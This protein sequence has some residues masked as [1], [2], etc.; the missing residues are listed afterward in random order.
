MSNLHR[1]LNYSKNYWKELTISILAAIFCG[2]FSAAPSWVVQHT[3]DDIFVKGL[4]HLIIPFIIGFILLFVCKGITTYFSSYYMNWVGHRVINDIRK[5]LFDRIIY[6]PL[7]FFKK[8]TTGELLAHFLNDIRMIQNAS[9]SAIKHGIRSAFEAVALLS[10]AI[11][12]NPKLSILI[13]ILAP[14]IIISIRRMG[15]AVRATAIT[16]QNEIGS[17]SSLLQETFVGVREIKA[18]NAEPY[19]CKRFKDH[20][21]RCFISLMNNVHA[22]SVGPAFIETI[23]MAG[24]SIIFYIAAHQV[25]QGTITPG[26]LTSFFAAI[27]LAF[28][29]IKRLLS[30]YTDIQNGLAAAD[31]IFAIMDIPCTTQ[32][33]TKQLVTFSNQVRFENVTFHYSDESPILQNSSFSIFKGEKIGIIGPSGAGKSTACDLILGFAKP[34]SGTVY[35]D[36]QDISTVT[37]QS[38]REQI[39]YVSQ[40]P[41]LF[42]DSIF[43]NITYATPQATFQE[44]EEAARLANIYE[45]IK[46]LPYQWD[47]LVGENGSLLSGGQKQRLTI[48]RALL[49]KPAILILDE[50][51]SALDT[52]SEELISRAIENLSKTITV[53]AVSHRP[54][55]MAKMDRI[56][57]IHDKKFLEIT[58]ETSLKVMNASLMHPFEVQAQ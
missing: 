21:D 27:L 19:E 8:R 54:S 34:I 41:F 30:A 4:T 10:V 29:P 24:A 11:I 55:L 38:L 28:Q 18:F 43:A 12:Q 26:Q 9:S 51:T 47:T 13:A 3:V 17:V 1:I 42:N 45:F 36:A 5:D 53:I 56:F 39:G 25:L 57:T 48:A 20:L 33:R 40:H 50:A 23:T 58:K 7:D 32:E 37:L 14:F 35:I 6:F 31:R 2:I 44:V 16:I 22:E 15:K 52:Q 49:K 46:S